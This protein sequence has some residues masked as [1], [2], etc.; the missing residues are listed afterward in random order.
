MYTIP[1]EFFFRIHHV[2]PR[3][4]NDVDSVLLFMAQEISSIP[5]LPKQEFAQILNSKI[6][7]YPG[8]A[9]RAEKTI[10]NWRTEISALFGFVITDENHI[11]KASNRAIELAESE[12]VVQ[13]FKKFLFTF[14]YPGHHIKP[15]EIA[16]MIEAGIKFK[17]AKSILNVFL[18]AEKE[19]GKHV[20]LT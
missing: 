4:K 13:A 10:N 16:K 5:P 19:E 1:N 3:F 7:A 6:Y 15:Q 8:N 14:Q 11:S 2:R 18:S 20:F 12:D 9:A 17:P